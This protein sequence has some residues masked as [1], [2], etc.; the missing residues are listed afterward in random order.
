MHFN[1]EAAN[2]LGNCVN[3]NE[4]WQGLVYH[5]SET[6]VDTPIF[7]IFWFLMLMEVY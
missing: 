3:L 4:L 1:E 7:Q 5:S 2:I 6:A